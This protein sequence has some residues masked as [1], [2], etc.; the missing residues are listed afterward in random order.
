[1]SY[2]TQLKYLAAY[3]LR[4]HLE[5]QDLDDR[6]EEEFIDELANEIRDTMPT[7]DIEK[8]RPFM[9]DGNVN[10][11]IPLGQAIDTVLNPLVEDDEHYV[12][13]IHEEWEYKFGDWRL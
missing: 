5:P 8:I 3:Y 7:A 4:H 1:M 6:L 11:W 10:E 12:D 9:I 2:L 13:H